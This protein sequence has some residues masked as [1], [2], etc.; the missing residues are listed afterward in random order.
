MVSITNADLEIYVTENSVTTVIWKDNARVL[1]FGDVVRITDRDGIRYEFLYTDVIAPTSPA[2]SS[3]EELADEIN[4][5]LITIPG[6]GGGGTIT[7]VTATAPLT[8]SGGATPDISTLMASGK[9]IGRHSSGSGVFQ[10]IT[11]GSNLSL[12]GDT[13]NATGGGGG[14]LLSGN[15]TQVSAGVYT[16]SIT[17]VTAYSAG[18]AYLIKF[19][20]ANDGAS[21]ININSLGAKNIFKNT[22]IPIASGDI[23]ANQEIMIVYDGTNFQAIGLIS[24]QLLAY[25]H[26]SQGSVI[27]K[28]QVVYAYQATG[29]KMSVK[30]ARADSDATSAKTIGLVYDSSIGIGGEGYIIIQGVIEG[31]NT[32]AFNAGDTLYLSGTTFGG[33]TATKPH[34]PTHLVYV[35]IVERANAGN[36]QIYVRCQNGYELDEIHDVDLISS[37]PVN[38]QLLTYEQSTDLWKNKSLGTILGGN[39]SQYVRGDGTLQTN[40]GSFGV[41]VDGIIG[42]VQVGTTGYV[43][44]PYDGTITSWVLTANASGTVSFDITKA[45]SGVIPTVSI[46]GGGGVYPTL[47]SQQI[48]TGSTL[49]GWTTTFSAGD[50]F[51]FSVRASPAPATIK[52]VTLTIRVTRL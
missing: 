29:N 50:V 20:T 10:E 2:Y 5:Y 49:T 24:S 35:G 19:G 16:S 26:N 8:S 52:N 36:G 23:K 9:L 22:N 17:G 44:M 7:D 3:A 39:T 32:A 33:V 41:T 48:L 38:N 13:L 28:G 37:A 43:V 18:D 34:A 45:S 1:A 11:L 14:G 27:N 4:T 30:L 25:V 47:S 31:I 46:I 15:A 42:I 21:T 40:A 12:S 51:G 6:G